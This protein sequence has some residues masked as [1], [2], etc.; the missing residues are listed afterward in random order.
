MTGFPS[1]YRSQPF[2][3]ISEIHPAFR[4]TP[5]APRGCSQLHGILKKRLGLH[6][7]QSCSEFMMYKL[8]LFSKTACGCPA[9]GC[10]A[11]QLASQSPAYPKTAGRPHIL[12]RRKTDRGQ[13][14]PVSFM[15]SH[16]RCSNTQKMSDNPC[17]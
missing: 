11:P 3:L 14:L 2:G 1:R 15:C 10:T 6:P 5:A 8:G 16:S 17:P 12:V 7:I 13:A 4:C 9:I